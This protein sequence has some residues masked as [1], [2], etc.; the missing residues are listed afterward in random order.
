MIETWGKN[1]RS[2]QG[3]QPKLELIQNIGSKYHTS[4]LDLSGLSNKDLNKLLSS[5][6]KQK[7]SRVESNKKK[8]YISELKKAFPKVE[9]FEKASLTGLRDLLE[10]LC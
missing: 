2:L 1:R 7:V 9:H 3:K 8:E 6:P 10:A 5:E 4:R